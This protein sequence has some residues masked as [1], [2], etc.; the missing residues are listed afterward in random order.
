MAAGVSP[1]AS[2]P[3]PTPWQRP[4][5]RWAAVVLGCLVAVYAMVYVDLVLRARHAYLQ[6]EKYMRWHAHPQEKKA[7]YEAR[8]VQQKEAL[9]RDRREGKLTKDEYDLK[10]ELARFET[11]ELIKE[12]SLKYAYLWY[13]TAAELFS[14]PES[15][16]VVLSRDKMRQAKEMWKQ[17][18][19]DQKIPFEDYMLE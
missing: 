1:P 14:P 18:L 4:W 11:D 10:L 6:A 17:E 13:Q 19:R 16:W 12:S 2:A 8:F 15:K 7:F 5:L 9:D 3:S